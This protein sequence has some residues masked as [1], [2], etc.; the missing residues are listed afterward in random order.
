MAVQFRVRHPVV[1]T[2]ASLLQSNYMANSARFAEIE[3]Q[4]GSRVRIGRYTFD[5]KAGELT[6]DGSKI[7]L[8]SQPHKIL[9]MLIAH[10]GEIVTREE[11]QQRLW[12][13]DVVISFEVSI[14]QA[15]NK[16]RRA[17][18]DSAENPRF[19]ETIGRRG[20]RLIAPVERVREPGANRISQGTDALNHDLLRTL[21]TNQ[22]V[23][24]AEE[25]RVLA[26][27]LVK[28]LIML[29]HGD[30]SIPESGQVRDGG[31]LS[32]KPV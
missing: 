14:N 22:V 3:P 30:L 1:L 4:V 24:G 20:Y 17:L 31:Q 19:I 15:V 13:S 11:I 29:G 28:L 10:P 23:Y 6:V 9:L 8:Q 32:S 18:N 26:A 25:L 12:S 27:T 21:A 2:M 7:V 5:P 16:L